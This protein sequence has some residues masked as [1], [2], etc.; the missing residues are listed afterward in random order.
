MST[1]QFL[2]TAV[3]DVKETFGCETEQ[4]D[5]YYRWSGKS[6]L[7][8]CSFSLGIEGFPTHSEKTSQSIITLLED[9]SIS[10]SNLIDVIREAI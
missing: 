9:T 2:Y 7:D 5:L 1:R 4:T 6:R 3:S 10:H 8:E